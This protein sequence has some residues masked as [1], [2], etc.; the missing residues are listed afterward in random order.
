MSKA[1]WIDD[2]E[3]AEVVERKGGMWTSTG[4][5]RRGKIYC[6]IEETL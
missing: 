3:M 2:L 5:V 4:I 6:S 1:L